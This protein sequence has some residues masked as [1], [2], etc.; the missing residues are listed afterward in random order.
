MVERRGNDVPSPRCARRAVRPV[1]V[2]GTIPSNETPRRDEV[3]R[4]NGR[5]RCALQGLLL[6]WCADDVEARRDL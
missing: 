3:T 5:S 4:R 2:R 1:R 6:E